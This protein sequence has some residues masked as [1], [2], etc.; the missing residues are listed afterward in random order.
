MASRSAFQIPAPQSEVRV[1]V[2]STFSD[3]QA[4]R[5]VLVKEVFP[6]L[7]NILA[8]RGITFIDIDLRW[9]IPD[10]EVSEGKVLPVC[11]DEIERCRPFFIGLLGQ[12]YGYIPNDIP[13]ELVQSHRWLTHHREKS[14]TELEIV[15]GALRNPS[16]ANRA[17][18]YFRAPEYIWS[19]AEDQRADFVES[20]PANRAKLAVLKKAIKD[21]EFPVRDNYPDPE[22]L[23]R[24]VFD[25]LLEA[26]DQEYPPGHP[27]NI[28]DQM[29]TEQIVFAGRHLRTYVAN[30]NLFDRIDRYVEGG[31]EPL[32]IIGAE[33]MGKSA[34][35]ANWV[36]RSEGSNGSRPVISH[37]LEAGSRSSQLHVLIL[38]L[39]AELIRCCEL[40]DDVPVTRDLVES[41]RAF[42][43]ILQKASDAGGITLILDGLDRLE[44]HR[45]R[46][47]LNWLPTPVPRHVRLI[48]SVSPGPLCDDLIARGCPTLTLQPIG[49]PDRV[50]LARRYLAQYSKALSSLQMNKITTGE[51]SG[52]SLWLQVVL[53]ELRIFGVFERLDD[54]ID[55]YIDSK[56]IAD[57]FMRVFQRWEDDYNRGRPNLVREVMELLWAS[58]RGLSEGEIAQALSTAEEPFPRAYLSPLFLASEQVLTR[59]SRIS[60][61]SGTPLL[62][63]P[64]KSLRKALEKKYLPSRISQKLA[65]LRVAEFFRDQENILRKIDEIPWQYAA[66]DDWESLCKFLSDPPNLK[67]VWNISRDDTRS[68]WARMETNSPLR[69]IQ[70]YGEVLEVPQKFDEDFVKIVASLMAD[71]GPLEHAAE[72]EM[73]LVDHYR[74]IGDIDALSR[75]L[76]DHGV[77]LWRMGKY[78]EATVL[79]REQEMLCREQG[80]RSTLA[81]CLGNLAIVLHAQGKFRDAMGF[82]IEE[83]RLCDEIGD[84]EGMQAC[85][86]NQAVILHD[87]GDMEGAMKRAKQQ[88]R[89]GHEVGNDDAVAKALGHQARVLQ[90]T[91]RVEEA[92]EYR[93]R[94]EDIYRNLGDLIGLSVSL[95]NQALICGSLGDLDAALVLHKE[96]ESICRK[97][98]HK[99]GLKISLGNQ[100]NVLSRNGRGSEAESLFEEQEKLCCELDDYKGLIHSL[101]N[102]A[103]LL[104]QVLGRVDKAVSL[105]E[106]AN[107][108]AV[109]HGISSVI[110]RINSALERIRSRLQ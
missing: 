97:T 104:S 92:L 74:R 84:R 25:D 11:L 41:Q 62:N 65:H 2:S 90:D 30:E 64:G 63:L 98:G 44:T 107:E 5:D 69:L 14:I 18:F 77:S 12:R 88:E 102:H 85:L 45:G 106:R 39:M 61:G 17:F 94:E 53:G 9:G 67:A 22:T 36:S 33:G 26:I 37:H 54:H 79:Y 38:R 47:H 95:G 1:F 6:E 58:R 8:Q 43:K 82:H 60:N 20:D 56:T 40:D 13:A 109:R 99:Q 86:G 96:E 51:I 35:L 7:R 15:H 52:H 108:L 4:E 48:A 28:L 105:A 21:N 100:A 10:E 29:A 42:I 87:L 50:E 32:V 23:G 24:L 3:M 103:M 59:S 31:G 68:Y 46:P 70:A 71:L 57:L 72:L 34:L 83:E 16:M 73:Y 75:S 19:I 76:G 66:A 78:Q 49:R 27:P 110:P 80:D 101:L 81:D 91:G 55:H 89:I 93:K